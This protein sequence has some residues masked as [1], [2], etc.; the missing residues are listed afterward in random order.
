MLDLLEK[1]KSARKTIKPVYIR[2]G[3]LQLLAL[4]SIDK[5]TVT[6]EYIAKKTGLRVVAAAAVMLRLSEKGLLVREESQRKDC[7]FVYRMT[8]MG[9]EQREKAK[10]I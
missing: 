6:N 4:N 3:K 2:M 10:F 9:I 1:A 7:K 5:T 8:K